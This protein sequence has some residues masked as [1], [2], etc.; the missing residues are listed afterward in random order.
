MTSISTQLLADGT[1]VVRPTGAMVGGTEPDTGLIGA[2]SGAV[3]KGQLRILLDLSEINAVDSAG[4][5]ELVRSW[6]HVRRAGGDV[7]FARP[8][9]SVKTTL[10]VTKLMPLFKTSDT[11]DAGLEQLRGGPTTPASV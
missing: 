10:E 5:A 4:V 6:I 11:L 9:Q 8:A 2:F 1:L 3:D 7:V